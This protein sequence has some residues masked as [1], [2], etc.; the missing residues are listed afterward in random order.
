MYADGIWLTLGALQLH[1][2]DDDAMQ[3]LETARDVDNVD[4]HNY[5]LLAWTHLTHPAHLDYGRGLDEAKRA[6]GRPDKEDP[7]YERVLAL[8]YLRNEAWADAVI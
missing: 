1:L 3:S 7:R 5:L 8:A 2:G 6:Q 4:E